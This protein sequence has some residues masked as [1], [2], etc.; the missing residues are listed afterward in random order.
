MCFLVQVSAVFLQPLNELKKPHSSFCLEEEL[1]DLDDLVALLLLLL[2]LRLLLFLVA[3]PA[4][5]LVNSSVYIGILVTPILSNCSTQSF[6]CA[7]KYSSESEN[8]AF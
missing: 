1:L 8:E 2:L 4:A 6:L 3:R 7:S 5:I